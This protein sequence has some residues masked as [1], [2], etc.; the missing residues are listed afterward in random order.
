MKTTKSLCQNCLKLLDLGRELEIRKEKLT[1]K[2]HR[3]DSD[4]FDSPSGPYKILVAFPLRTYWSVLSSAKFFSDLLE[5]WWNLIRSVYLSWPTMRTKYSSS[6]TFPLVKSE[7]KFEIQI[8]AYGDPG[9]VV[10]HDPYK[11]N[12]SRVFLFSDHLPKF[13]GLKGLRLTRDILCCSF[14]EKTFFLDIG[15]AKGKFREDRLRLMFEFLERIWKFKFK[16]QEFGFYKL[17]LG[18]I[19]IRVDLDDLTLR[20]RSS[21]LFRPFTKIFELVVDNVSSSNQTFLNDCRKTLS[22]FA[23]NESKFLAFLNS[24]APK[25]QKIVDEGKKILE[26]LRSANKPFKVWKQLKRSS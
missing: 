13:F 9:L 11:D 17:V 10:I 24:V 3:L 19:E 4:F 22:S 7:E 5:E 8:Q 25:K 16:I 15:K 23:Q 12:F 26:D 2:I 20:P 18:N 21:L 6:I 14:E 1:E